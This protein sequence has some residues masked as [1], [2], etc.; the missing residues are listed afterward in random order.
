L[1]VSP[2][3]V[4][5][6]RKTLS[7]FFAWG[8]RRNYGHSPMG[9]IRSDDLPVIPAAS[10]GTLSVEQCVAL[11]RCV[12]ERWAWLERFR[13]AGTAGGVNAAS[14]EN[15]NDRLPA[16]D[17]ELQKQMRSV[18]AKNITP[19]ISPWP[20]NAL[21]HTFCTML[22]SLYSDAARVANWSR[23]SAPKQ[24]YQ[25]YVTKLVSPEE[26]KRFCEILPA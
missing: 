17:D 6:Y 26:A 23:H 19:R 16:P 7:A 2:K 12:A 13:A 22:I 4:L 8:E 25:S 14:T 15:E 21:R 18:F 11:M 24:L 3:T 20:H 9:S 5:N 1:G 10:K